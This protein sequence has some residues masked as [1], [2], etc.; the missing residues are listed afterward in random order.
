MLDHLSGD[1][2]AEMQIF[3]VDL[4]NTLI[5]NCTGECQYS[6]IYCPQSDESNS[7]NCIVDCSGPNG[8]I[9]ANWCTNIIWIYILLKVLQ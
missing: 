8:D 2:A 1:A 6:R 4:I 7:D 5:V 3:A 9:K